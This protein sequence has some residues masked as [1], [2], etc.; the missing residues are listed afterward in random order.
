MQ[1]PKPLSALIIME[2]K[3]NGYRLHMK[4]RESS[5]TGKTMNTAGNHNDLQSDT[6]LLQSEDISVGKDNTNSP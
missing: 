1:P 3:R 5:T 4:K 2:R 6:A